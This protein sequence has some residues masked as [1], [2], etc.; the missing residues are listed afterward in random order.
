MKSHSQPTHRKRLGQGIQWDVQI[1][2]LGH[3]CLSTTPVWF[4]TVT[5]VQP[6][7]SWS[8]RLSPKLI[9][10]FLH[11]AFLD[12]YVCLMVICI[13]AAQGRGSIHFFISCLQCLTPWL[14][15]NIEPPLVQTHFPLFTQ[16]LLGWGQWARCQREQRREK[17]PD[18][19]KLVQHTWTWETDRQWSES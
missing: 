17:N 2:A 6:E 8:S 19:D 11:E 10:W 7:T 15:I 14:W 12:M 18:Q 4:K 5:T 3:S 16:I 9:C 1:L 13:P